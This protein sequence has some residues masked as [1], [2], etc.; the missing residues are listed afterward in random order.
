MS[1]VCNQCN[2]TVDDNVAFCPGCGAQL[3]VPQT[4]VQ[5]AQPA[6]PNAQIVNT[7]AAKAKVNEVAGQAKVKGKEFIEK[8]KTDKN[9]Q[10]TCCGVVVGIIVLFVLFT[11]LFPSSNSVLK[12]YMKGYK[13]FNAKQ[14]GKY[15]H[16][17]VN[18][19]YEDKLDESYVDMLDESFE[20][21]EDRDYKILSYEINKDY[22]AL[23]KSKVEDIAD[24]L[25]DNYDIP[26]KSVKTVRKYSVKIKV[27]ED[28]EKD[29]TK[30]TKCLV[31]IGMKWY[32]F[33]GI[34][35]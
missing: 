12:G 19:Y 25:E 17:K 2:L 7:E 26:A 28:D 14:V 8:I 11:M 5:Q 15:V 18:E 20:K 35:E 27:E 22:K 3:P 29:T 6:D 24:D 31:K 21:M 30:T 16:P 33:E 1:K 34:C 4:T 23:S 13:N 9:T 10:M 32:V